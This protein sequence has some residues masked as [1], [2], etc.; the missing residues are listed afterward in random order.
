MKFKDLKLG[1]KLGVG[2]GILILIAVALGL[3]AVVNMQSISTQ[4]KHLANEYIP[5]VEVANNLERFTILTMYEIR[6]YAFTE[7][8]TYYNSGKTSLQK[9]NRYLDDADEL[10]KKST[11]TGKLKETIAET[12]IAVA[13]YEQLVTKTVELNVKLENLRS[14]M[15]AAASE[16]L[17]N[18]SSYLSYQNTNFKQEYAQGAGNLNERHSKITWLNNIIDKGNTVRVANF[19]AQAIR[20]PAKQKNAI[21]NFNISKELQNLRQI[22]RDA[23]NI[24]ELNNIENSAKLYKNAMQNFHTL[25]IEREDINTQRT[26]T[27]NSVLAATQ[28]VANTGI[29]RTKDVANEAVSLLGSSSVVMIVGLFVALLIGI[30]LAIYLTNLITSPIRKGVDF[31]KAIAE[32]DLNAK[33]DVEQK[34]EVGQLLD[35][36]SNM[37]EKL[38][39]IITNV[40][41]GADNIAAASLE[42]SGTSQQMS[43]GA[44]EQ[45]SSTEEV[46]SSMEEMSANIQQNTDNAQ[47]TERI[48]LKAAEGIKQGN[49]ASQKS[50]GAMK[51]IAEKISIVNEIAFQTNILALN[52][53]VEAA[54]AGEHGKGFAVV[55]AEVRKLAERSAKA[56]GEIDKV[57]KEGLEISEN[58]GK[59]LADIV[60]EIG[61]TAS[62][63]QEIAASSVEQSSGANQVN[64]AIGQLNQV[65]QQNAA[66]SE[67]MATSSE[68][69]SSQA[70]QLKEIV[71]YFKV[72]SS[73]LHQQSRRKKQ[74]QTK[75]VAHINEESANNAGVMLDLQ[76]RNKPIDDGY[77]TF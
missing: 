68:E 42:M 9:L 3:L 33:I 37:V 75:K 63:V 8:N 64:T 7:E 72:D 16:F 32:G 71:S 57:S 67:E 20:D 5:E 12:R 23:Q 45:A 30:L 58:A 66:A 35:A 6:G 73:V 24:T 36:L 59:Q 74:S 13:N 44:N 53:A 62:L 43:Q 2:F 34:D 49:D 77:E 18:C 11:Q 28:N 19:K 25:W 48:A 41:S 22:T 38:K 10:A 39:E 60:P 56:A 4:S 27:G 69:L 14:N 52:A 54:R 31:A 70:E 65:T 1:Q 21:D 29:E 17:E 51:E 15:D 61:K 40:I 47:Q 50:V 55:A 26:E 46:S 76:N